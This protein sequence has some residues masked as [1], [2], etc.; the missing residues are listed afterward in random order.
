MMMNRCLLL[1]LSSICLLGVLC[2]FWILPL[3]PFRLVGNLLRLQPLLTG[4]P[5]GSSP[6]LR[7]LRLCLA[8]RTR[9]SPFSRASLCL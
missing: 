2:S 8:G 9:V 7:P 4:T 6:P 5:A 3:L 1:L